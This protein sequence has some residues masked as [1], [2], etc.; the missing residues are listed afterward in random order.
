MS[1]K[2]TM[3][4]FGR[5]FIMR[6]R[7]DAVIPEGADIRYEDEYSS[8]GGCE[9]CGPEYT[10]EVEISYTSYEKGKRPVYYEATYSGKFGDLMQTILSWEEDREQ[11]GS[12]S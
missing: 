4:A 3:N 11:A 1:A 9:T 6:R 8:Y 7:P 10:Y 12:E 2:D 5:E